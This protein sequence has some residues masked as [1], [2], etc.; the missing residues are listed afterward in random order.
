MPPMTSA[1]PSSCELRRLLVEQE[2]R[3]PTVV[4]GWTSRMIDVTT[5]GSRGSEIEMHR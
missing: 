4:T 5:A 3:E 1:T 2:H